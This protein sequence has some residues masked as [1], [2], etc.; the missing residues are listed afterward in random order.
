MS[1]LVFLNQEILLVSSW[2]SNLLIVI[3]HTMSTAIEAQSLSQVDIE[4]GVNVTFPM[5]KGGNISA[6][7][8]VPS[9]AISEKF[10][11]L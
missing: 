8:E 11:N 1:Q 3:D 5:M 9:A 2:T 7:S 10:F 4:K 6:Q